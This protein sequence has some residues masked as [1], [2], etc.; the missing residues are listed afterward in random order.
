MR[1]FPSS[2]IL[3][4]PAMSA[5]VWGKLFPRSELSPLDE[6]CPSEDPLYRMILEAC[7]SWRPRPP[8][9]EPSTFFVPKMARGHTCETFPSAQG[10]QD[11]G[12]TPVALERGLRLLRRQRFSFAS[13]MKKQPISW[14]L[15][16]GVHGQTHMGVLSLSRA[17][18]VTLGKLLPLSEPVFS[19]GEWR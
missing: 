18:C 9:W 16:F 3:N 7:E 4:T 5:C 13:C 19:S 17:S 12:V 11:A 15:L 2:A 8:T 14:R 1:S 10:P 6:G